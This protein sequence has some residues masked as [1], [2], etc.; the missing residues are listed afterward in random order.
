MTQEISIVLASDIIYVTGTVN[1]LEV[2]FSLSGNEWRAVAPRA[3]DGIYNIKIVAYDAVGNTATHEIVKQYGLFL[4]TDRTLQDVNFAANNRDSGIPLKGA[5]NS[6]DFNR[7]GVALNYISEYL[8]IL[9]YG[10]NPRLRTDWTT[11]ENMSYQ[12]AVE[13]LEII[14]QVKN[15]Y[16]VFT[17]PFPN[18]IHDL[19]KPNGHIYANNIEQMFFDIE[20]FITKMISAF[21]FSGEI[22][23]GEDDFN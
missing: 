20:N 16:T 11:T 6:E 7:V 18:H 10:L 17:S 12:N 21:I 1:G 22:S 13:Y 3:T 2:T 4:I 15:S 14:K 23:A 8:F 5:Y 9:G 19:F